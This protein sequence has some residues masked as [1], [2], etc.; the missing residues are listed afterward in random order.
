MRGFA[1]FQIH[2]RCGSDAVIKSDNNRKMCTVSVV[3]NVPIRTND[4][5]TSVKA[6]WFYFSWFGNIVDSI[7]PRLLKGAPVVV[8]GEIDGMQKEVDGK[9][10]T[11]YIFKPRA[12]SI[13]ESSMAT[14][15]PEDRDKQGESRRSRGH[16]SEREVETT[17]YDS[18][19]DHVL[20]LG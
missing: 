11:S 4:G 20:R 2:G 14:R 5:S 19:E 17:Y 6:V 18:D 12:V 8:L 13:I 10:F 3:A 15:R 9:R 7:A 1:N 16:G